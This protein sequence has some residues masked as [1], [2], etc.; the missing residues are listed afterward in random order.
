M[1]ALIV[2]LKE[3]LKLKNID[4]HYFIKDTLK[5]KASEFESLTVK[6]FDTLNV[7]EKQIKDKITIYTEVLERTFHSESSNLNFIKHFLSQKLLL[8]SFLY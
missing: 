3:L 4:L 5:I 8:D 2:K 1:N 7:K 6:N